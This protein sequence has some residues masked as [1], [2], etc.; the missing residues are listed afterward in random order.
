MARILYSTIVSKIAGKV[1][2]TVFTNT[3]GGA[4][5]LQP[6][7]SR[8]TKQAWFLLAN[9]VIQEQRNNVAVV[10]KTWQTLSAAQMTAW[11][12]AARSYSNKNSVGTATLPTGMNLFVATNTNLLMIGLGITAVPVPLPII[13]LWTD[14]TFTTCSSTAMVI[15]LGSGTPAG[16]FLIVKGS[17]ACSNGL[18]PRSMSFTRI[19]SA[20]SI[21]AGAINMYT[22]YVPQFGIPITGRY[23][24]LQCSLMN[25]TS[26]TSSPAFYIKKI[27][28]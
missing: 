13:S 1:G 2:N 19:F 6:K 4:A 5:I 28:S 24:T 21:S 7:H 20:G 27:V 3:L 18:N 23:I 26:G 16:W 9:Q 25:A 10:S 15:T 11:N 12:V 8:K 17:V 14:I 22:Y